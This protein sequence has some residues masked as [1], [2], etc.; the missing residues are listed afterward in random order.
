[1]PNDA[2]PPAFGRFVRC[3]NE[4]ARALMCSI[5]HFSAEENIHS[6]HC[7]YAAATGAFS[8]VPDPDPGPM[9]DYWRYDMINFSQYTQYKLENVTGLAS[10]VELHPFHKYDEKQ[11]LQGHVDTVR[12]NWRYR[13]GGVLA[14]AHSQP[15]WKLVQSYWHSPARTTGNKEWDE[16]LDK[17]RE[18]GPK[19]DRGTLPCPVSMTML[20]LT[21]RRSV[22]RPFSLSLRV[23]AV[24]PQL[25]HSPTTLNLHEQYV[26]PLLKTVV[27]PWRDR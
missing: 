16:L 9:L 27:L 21:M 2:T 26:T 25:A 23:R 8:V 17:I 11:I 22:E 6:F 13:Q 18:E 24:F 10:L 4:L 7:L 20:H 5:A 12:G 3:T 15:F 14:A 1:M 19:F